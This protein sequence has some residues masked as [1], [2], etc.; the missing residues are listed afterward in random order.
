MRRTG[1]APSRVPGR[2]IEDQQI[3][4]AHGGTIRAENRRAPDGKVLY[5]KEGKMDMVQARRII[6]AT[7]PDTRGYIGQKAYWTAAI[8]QTPAK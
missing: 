2:R 1:S 6:L 4:D 7:L 3:V 8:G 5:Q